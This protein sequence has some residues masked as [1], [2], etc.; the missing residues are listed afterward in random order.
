MN[1][2]SFIAQLVAELAWPVTVLICILWLRPLLARLV[3]LI[4]TLKYSDVEIQF[5][6]EVAELKLA[7]AASIQPAKVEARQEPIWEDLVRLASVRPRTAILKSWQQVEVTLIQTAKNRHLEVAGTVWQMPMVLGALMLNTGN[8]S[9]H[10]Y[11]LLTR[12]RQLVNEAT[13]APVDSV[14]PGD[15]V[16]FVELALRLAGSLDPEEH[17]E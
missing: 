12:L 10:Q 6:R 5:G 2:R 17:K 4:R 13:H 14:N 8:I 15:A 11:D 9:V 3:P 1:T 7:A 16:E